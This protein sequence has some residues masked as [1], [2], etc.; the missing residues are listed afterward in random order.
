MDRELWMLLMAFLGEGGDR[1]RRNDLE[2]ILRLQLRDQLLQQAES[3]TA[4]ALREQRDR[5]RRE[6]R[7]ISAE[8]L[9]R[10]LGRPPES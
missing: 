1:Q 7:R 4:Q 6:R 3:R 2:Q 8:Q 10:L 9:R 5:L